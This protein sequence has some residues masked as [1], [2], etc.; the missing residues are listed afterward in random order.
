MCMGSGCM[1]DY[2]VCLC[3]LVCY[4]GVLPVFLAV[5]V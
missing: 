4:Q 1:S 3:E 5:I 2:G